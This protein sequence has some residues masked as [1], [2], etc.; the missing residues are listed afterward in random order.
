[1]LNSICEPPK[2]VCIIRISEQYDTRQ[3]NEEINI[4]YSDP[5]AGL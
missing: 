5:F 4:Y 2:N 1:M 3:K